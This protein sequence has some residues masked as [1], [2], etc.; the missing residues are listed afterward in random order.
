M[1]HYFFYNAYDFFYPFCST[2]L[3]DYKQSIMNQGK[4]C[5]G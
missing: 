4:E 3:S 1:Q 2:I 5:S